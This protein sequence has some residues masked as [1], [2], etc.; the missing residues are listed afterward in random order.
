[1]RLILDAAPMDLNQEID[2]LYGLPLDE[3]TAARNELAAKLRNEGERTSAD[4]VKRLAKP[5]LPAWTVNQLCRRDQAHVAAL[6]AAGGQLREAQKALLSGS[7]GE[8]LKEAT[9]AERAAITQLRQR[10]RSLLAEAG[11]PATSATLERVSA[12][13]RAAAV[14]EEGRR[15]LEQGRLSEEIELVGFDALGGM[16]SPRRRSEQKKTP[17]DMPTSRGQQQELKRRQRELTV[18]VREL[19]RQAKAAERE[20]NR[21][22]AAATRAREAADQ[23][24]QRAQLAAT[25]LAELR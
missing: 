20:A 14:D 6:L 25:Q 22:E 4:D 17:R 21:A 13:L 16:E 15:L 9:A 18:E 2:D 19:E 23:A 12:T 24:R 7:G 8:A 5:T 10:A 11:R 1:M 3:F